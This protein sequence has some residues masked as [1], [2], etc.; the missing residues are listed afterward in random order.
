MIVK[1]YKLIIIFVLEV[2]VFVLKVLA[3]FFDCPAAAME[4]AEV[5]LALG[6]LQ[7]PASSLL[8]GCDIF[9]K[10]SNFSSSR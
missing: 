6:V 4:G 1:R 5:I 2:R 9:H 8:Y 10:S 7:L 3:E